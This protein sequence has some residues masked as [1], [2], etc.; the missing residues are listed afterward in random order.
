MPDK[1]RYYMYIQF[2][3]VNE[4]YTSFNQHINLANNL[5]AYKVYVDKYISM[6]QNQQ[7]SGMIR[8]DALLSFKK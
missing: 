8:R 1:N 7:L 4:V 3:G 6:L 2:E 5:D